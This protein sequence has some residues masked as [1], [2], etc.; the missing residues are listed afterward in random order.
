MPPSV[1][2]GLLDYLFKTPTSVLLLILFLKILFIYLAACL[3]CRTQDL[4]L[5][6]VAHGIL[7]WHRDPF[8]ARDQNLGPLHWEHG[9]LATLRATREV[10]LCSWLSA[11]LYFLPIMMLSLVIFQSLLKFVFFCLKVSI[12]RILNFALFT[13]SYAPAT[14]PWHSVGAHLNT[15]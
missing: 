7:S 10:P 1:E 8:L 11:L 14:V 4:D 2:A 3:S 13:R 5:R 9:V 15:L 12:R 6:F